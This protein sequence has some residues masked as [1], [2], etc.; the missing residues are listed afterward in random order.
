MVPPGR[1]VWRGVRAEL[2]APAHCFLFL[3]FVSLIKFSNQKNMNT[4]EVLA[5]KAKVEMTTMTEKGTL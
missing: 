2:I 3:I 5:I 1:C 4:A